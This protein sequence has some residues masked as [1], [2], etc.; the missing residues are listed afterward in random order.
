MGT[1]GPARPAAVH[2]SHLQRAYGVDYP[3]TFFNFG[4]FIL[5]PAKE[6]APTS[7]LFLHGPQVLKSLPIFAEPT[8]S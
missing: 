2:P 5:A 1:W 3:C 4:T 8:H 7:I 6:A